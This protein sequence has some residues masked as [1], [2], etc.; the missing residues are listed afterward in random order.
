MAAISPACQ[1][2]HFHLA[3]PA[4]EG[5]QKMKSNGLSFVLVA[6]LLAG[7]QKRTVSNDEDDANPPIVARATPVPTPDY[8]PPGVFYLLT[9]VRKET[10]DG[11]ARLLPGTEVKLLRNGKYQTPE[12]EMALDPRTLTNDRTA[13]RAAQEADRK[14]QAVALPK[15]PPVRAVTVAATVPRAQ[16]SVHAHLLAPATAPVAATT[17]PA[18]DTPEQ[19]RA[20]QFKLSTL[21]NEEAKLQAN[22]AYLWEKSQRPDKKLA[23]APPGLGSSSSLDDYEGLK[24]RLAAVQADISTLETR[25]QAVPK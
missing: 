2:P 9:S 15:A 4:T 13:A 17:S 16:S 10:R 6:L 5:V 24:V 12:G 21:K 11:I 14:G 23:G 18:V 3:L 20:M 22:L 25:L 19:V 7:C 8:A 1:P